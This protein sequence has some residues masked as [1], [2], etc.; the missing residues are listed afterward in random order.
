M[1]KIISKPD[2]RRELEQ[3][4]SDYISKGG[5]VDQVERGLS[6]RVNPTEALKPAA[7]NDQSKTERTYLPDVVATLDARKKPQK[8]AP[9]RPS[10][11]R[12]KMIYDDFGEPLRWEWVED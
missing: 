6:G 11:P 9:K 10:R 2:I 8:P 7:F 4:I 1:K 3:Q 12:K 5:E